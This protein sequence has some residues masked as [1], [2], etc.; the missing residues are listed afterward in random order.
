MRNFFRNNPQ[1]FVLL[2]ICVILGVGTFI[3]VLIGLI[4]SGSST[5]NGEPSGTLVPLHMMVVLR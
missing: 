1:V 5:T 2:L 3:A 4:S